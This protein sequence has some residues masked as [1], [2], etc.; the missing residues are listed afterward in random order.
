MITNKYV[1]IHGSLKGVDQTD[2]D[3]QVRIDTSKDKELINKRSKKV[4]NY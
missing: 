2:S 1:K 3:I 4:N